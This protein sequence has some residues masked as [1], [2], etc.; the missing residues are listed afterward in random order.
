MKLSNKVNNM[1]FNENE[2]RNIAKQKLSEKNFSEAE[3]LFAKVILQNPNCL[4][5]LTSLGIINLEKKRLD[6]AIHFFNEALKLDHLNHTLH[7]NLGF[8]HHL[9]NNPQS[10]LDSYNNS[11]KLKPTIMA[12]NNLAN[13]LWTHNKK[14]VAI[15]Y[16]KASLKIDKNVSILSNLSTYLFLENR[17]VEAIEYSSMALEPNQRF[18][19][20]PLV[21]L[22]NSIN[23][24]KKEE[25]PKDITKVLEILKSI[26]KG[27]SERPILNANFFKLVLAEF[28]TQELLKEHLEKDYEK[29]L[30]R[31]ISKIINDDEKLFENKDFSKILHSEI[32]KLYISNNLISNKY[33]ENIYTKYRKYLLFLLNDETKE[34]P[35]E[36]NEF[37][38]SLSIQMEL[39]GYIWLISQEEQLIIK[40]MKKNIGQEECLSKVLI[41]SCYS[42]IKNN[43]MALDI[44]E[45]NKN[46]LSGIKKILYKNVEEPLNIINEAKNI[47]VIGNITD[48]VSNKV[49][50]QYEQYPYPLFSSKFYKESTNQIERG[51][52]FFSSELKD[53]DKNNEKE[54]LIAGCGTGRE[55][56]GMAFIHSKSNILAIDLSLNSL[57]YGSIKAQEDEI[58]NITFKQCDILNVSEIDKKFDIIS[59]CGVLHHMEKPHKGL[60][61]LV[62]ILNDEGAMKLALY[63]TYARI[64]LDFVRD[65]IKDNNLKNNEE[66][67]RFL[68]EK[69]KNKEIKID[70][71]HIDDLES[72]LDFY[73][74]NEFRDLLFHPQEKTYTLP[75]VGDLLDSCGLRF[76]EFDNKYQNLKNA[77]LTNFPDDKFGVNLENWDNLEKKHKN[78]FSSMYIFWVKKK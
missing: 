64:G 3:S 63:S 53:V 1:S 23:K 69:I 77:Y 38:C 19:L 39:N 14:E 52:P 56:I 22:F 18:S 4:E 8:S 55:A 28:N 43:K 48:D 7:F 32:M 36:L 47:D 9:N 49:R 57:A 46:K 42:S 5:S 11:I 72:S 20:A 66:D 70:D 21:T 71:E 51:S 34:F 67:I 2:I 29:L 35:N 58:N 54:I 31:D 15:E 30:T 60:K 44:L 50:D 78:L 6:H 13:L 68:R 33:L 12:Y 16:L 45:K 40:E 17:F 73:S 59:S 24:L 74:I 76:I 27:N 41:I 65:F 62:N 61:S 75:E 25:Y 26:F 10:A 37:L